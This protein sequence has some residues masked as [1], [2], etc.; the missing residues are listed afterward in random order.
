MNPAHPPQGVSR[1]VPRMRP[2][3]LRV[4]LLLFL[5]RGGAL[6]AQR[7]CPAGPTALVLSGNTTPADA[8]VQIAASG[9]IPTHVCA[10]I[11]T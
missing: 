10:S 3:W 7:A 1:Y 2:H 8:E 9:I 5:V 6:A 11:L 4:L